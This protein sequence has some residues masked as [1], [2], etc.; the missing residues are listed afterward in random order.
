MN[1]HG[2]KFVLRAGNGCSQ[3]PRALA[4]AGFEVTAIDISSTAVQA[5]KNFQLNSEG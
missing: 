5:A 3:E 4:E 1:I 2:L